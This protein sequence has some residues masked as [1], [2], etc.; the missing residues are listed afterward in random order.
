MDWGQC[1]FKQVSAEFLETSTGD[2]LLEVNA[3]DELINLD[4]HLQNRGQVSLCLLNLCLQL[5]E[6][7]DIALD[8]NVVLLLENL[9][10]VLGQSL[11]EILS[12]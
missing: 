9:N 7:T 12:T 3:I 1:L 10:E 6:S 2:S 11:V 8:V 4:F 5:L